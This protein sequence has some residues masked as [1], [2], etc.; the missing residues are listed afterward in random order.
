[1][2]QSNRHRQTDTQLFTGQMPFL[3]D[4]NSV[5]ALKEVSEQ[6]KKENG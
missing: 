1:M 5:G 2:L 4:I 3:L 6:M